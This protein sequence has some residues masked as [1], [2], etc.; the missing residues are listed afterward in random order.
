MTRNEAAQINGVVKLDA[1]H[2]RTILVDVYG[3]KPNDVAAL[4]KQGWSAKNLVLA[5]GAGFR[6]AQ[7]IS[8]IDAWDQRYL[9][10]GHLWGN[11]S[12]ETCQILSHTLRGNSAQRILEVGF[13]Y[14]RDLVKLVQDGYIV[15][16][17]EQSLVGINEAVRRLQTL[18]IF[19][20]DK[21]SVDFGSFRTAS[22]EGD[23]Y[24]AVFHHRVMHLINPRHYDSF[25]KRTA[26]VLREGG[27]AVVSARDT[28]DFNPDQ[29]NVAETTL[30][31][32]TGKEK[33]KT[34]TYKNRDNHFINFWDHTRFAEVYGSH[35]EILEL[36]R[37]KE[38]E[39]E[40][41]I[42][43]N[44][45]K[46]MTTFTAAVMRKKPSF[47]FRGV[48]GNG[49]VQDNLPPVQLLDSYTLNQ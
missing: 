10:E 11:D 49:S 46:V 3:W 39:S 31:T 20:A 6:N 47:G 14:G 44:G 41:N 35:F 28:E 33:P 13:G 36:Y 24:D 12:S 7:T 42:D 18:E 9:T 26:E 15:H 2:F 17:V 8:K 38:Q 40:G 32:E 48:N 19:N 16:G 1:R 25:V 37:G 27:I 23:F 5:H 34:A 30:D 29:M 43:E 45:K 22:L 4:E 21:L